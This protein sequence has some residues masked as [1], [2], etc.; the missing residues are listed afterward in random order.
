[1]FRQ[2]WVMTATFFV[3]LIPAIYYWKLDGVALLFLVTGLG[4]TVW[5]FLMVADILDFSL[6]DELRMFV[7][8]IIASAVMAAL[9][10]GVGLLMGVTLRGLAVQVAVGILTYVVCMFLLTKG[11]IIKEGKHLLASARK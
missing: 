6:L 3:L 8:P 2:T 10:L 4:S 7:S 1:M 9:C 5:V 11:E